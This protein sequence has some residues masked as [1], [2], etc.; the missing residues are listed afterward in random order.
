M[1]LTEAF[2]HSDRYTA[3]TQ[4]LAYNLKQFREHKKLTS[5]SN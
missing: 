2:S 5:R 4:D 3:L 1:V